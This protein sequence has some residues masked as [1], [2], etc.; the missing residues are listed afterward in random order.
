MQ[1]KKIWCFLVCFAFF[2]VTTY[3]AKKLVI[4]CEATYFG[5]QAGMQSAHSKKRSFTW[6]KTN[7]SSCL[8]ML[9]V[10]TDQ[11]LEEKSYFQKYFGVK[12]SVSANGRGTG[13]NILW[14]ISTAHSIC[15]DWDWWILM[16]NMLSSETCVLE[17][18]KYKG[19]TNK[20][21]LYSCGN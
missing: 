4:N 13:E 2:V 3:R 6:Q 1:D 11:K 18:G 9:E 5:Y 17:N 20:R 16:S 19:H 14:L 21:I 12:S 15:T 7:P 10:H 8:A